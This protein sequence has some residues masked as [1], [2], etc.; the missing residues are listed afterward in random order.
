VTIRT[1]RCSRC[2]A[3]G[4]NSRTCRGVSARDAH[5]A[6]RTLRLLLPGWI[7]VADRYRTA[8]EN[9]ERHITPELREAWAE[10]QA[11]MQASNEVAITCDGLIRKLPEERR[12]ALY[13]AL[14]DG[15]SRY[16][17]VL[18]EEPS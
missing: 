1:I 4:H 12:E 13:E 2:G 7:A 6:E 16:N 17:E 10:Q 8:M 5:D 15:F 11:A 3:I 14:R 9:V 18:N